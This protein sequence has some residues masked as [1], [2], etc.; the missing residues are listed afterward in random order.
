[1]VQPKMPNQNWE[2]RF[3]IE[4]LEFDG[5]LDHEEFVGWLSQVEEIFACYDIPESK[6]VKLA[7]TDLRG[8]GRSWWEQLKIQRLRE[9]KNK[10]QTWEKL[11]Q[12][13]KKQFFPYSHIQ[14]H[15]SNLHSC[16]TNSNAANRAVLIETQQ[17]KR[18]QSALFNSITSPSGGAA[19]NFTKHWRQ[20][21]KNFEIGSSTTGSNEVSKNQPVLS[22]GK[23]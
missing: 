1:M 3:E 19:S 8:K 10:I 5:C 4:F 23:T 17:T 16:W 14:I 15:Y 20:P 21:T 12:K 18:Y 11:K 13:L 6:K 9:G 22:K 7:A 2:S